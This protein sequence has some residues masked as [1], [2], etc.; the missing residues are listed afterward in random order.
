MPKYLTSI[1]L[2]QN[3]LLNAIIHNVADLNSIISPFL[4]QIAYNT[5]TKHLYAYNGSTWI[6]CDSTDAAKNV[7]QNMTDGI[8]TAVAS[9]LYDTFTFSAGSGISATIN[10]ANDSLTVTNTDLGSAS[11]RVVVWA[12]GDG[13][14]GNTA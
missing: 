10:P 6:L 13:R 11:G 3:E 8:N 9:G 5:T 12:A 1:D 7:Y 2:T 14:V 4:G